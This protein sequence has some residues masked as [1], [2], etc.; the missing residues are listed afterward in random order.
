MEQDV[1]DRARCEGLRRRTASVW[2][3]QVVVG[4]VLAVG[5][6][7]FW[8]VIMLGPGFGSLAALV[9]SSLALNV[10]LALAHVR[11]P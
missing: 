1:R 6:Y 11:R 9:A 8:T 10:T 2:T 3:L 5:L 4:V 7:R